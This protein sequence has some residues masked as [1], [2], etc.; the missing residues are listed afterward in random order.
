LIAKAKIWQKKSQ[1]AIGGLL[2]SGCPV[3]VL[4]MF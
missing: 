2:A 1:Q 3:S 4:F